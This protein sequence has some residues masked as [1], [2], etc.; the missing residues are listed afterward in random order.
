MK[1]RGVD[2]LTG[3]FVLTLGSIVANDL[4]QKKEEPVIEPV[5]EVILEVITEQSQKP[6]AKPKGFQRLPQSEKVFL[7][8]L[9]SVYYD[10]YQTM[11]RINDPDKDL[12]F[13]GRKFVCP[14]TTD[15]KKVYYSIG[16]A[17]LY[18]EGIFYDCEENDLYQVYHSDEAL[19]FIELYNEYRLIYLG[20]KQNQ[21]FETFPQFE[22]ALNEEYTEDLIDALEN[23]EEATENDQ[24]KA[25]ADGFLY[26]TK[27][28][29]GF[30]HKEQLQLNLEFVF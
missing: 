6:E 27:T 20:F 4:I 30:G 8:G 14:L 2:I 19:T 24:A 13:S 1:I 29:S 3:A 11:I 17:R 22:K 15:Y 26:I 28:Y 23:W 7:Q 5:E 9:I 12:P 21:V 25:Q 16:Q 18:S 10:Q